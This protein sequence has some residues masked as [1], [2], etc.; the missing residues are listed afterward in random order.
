MTPNGRTV[1]LCM[2]VKDE[3][4]VIARCLASVR[5]I[6]DH[7]IIVDTGS[8]DG[9]QDVVRA[10]MAG[11]PGEL[12]E[13]PWVDFA[14]NRSEALA[15]A[16]P[17]AD[18][19]FI[20]DA[21]DE[22]ALPPGFALPA[23]D[24]DSC[25]I[26]I[27]YSA[28]TYQ[29][30][31]FVRN[32]LEW[33]YRGVIH[34]FLECPAATTSA[35]VPIVMKINHEGRRSTDP[36]TYAKDAAI[37]E[38]ALASESD[39]FLVSRYTFYLAQSWRDCGEREKA[40]A[41]YLRR[42]E[43]GYWAEEVFVSL[44]NAGRLME[45]LGRRED[46]IVGIY[47]RATHVA[48]TRAEALHAASRF[49]RA[50]DRFEDGYWWAKRGIG[51][52]VPGA[53]LFVEPWIFEYGLLDELAVHA[54]WSERFDECRDACDR[55]LSE[56]KM[57]VHM[58]GRVE[59]N[60]Q[61]AIKRLEEVSSSAAPVSLLAPQGAMRIVATMTTIPSRIE[62]IEPV[63]E[64]VLNQ[65]KPVAHLEINIPQFC[66]RTG[67][68][69]RIPDWL[70]SNRKVRIYRTEDYGPI[71]K[72]APTL[73]RYDVDPDTYIWSVDDDCVYPQNQLEILCRSHHKGTHRILT[74][75]GGVLHDDGAVQF[76]YGQ[77]N[78]SMLEGFGGVLYPPSCIKSDFRRFIEQTSCDQD[79]VKNDD[80]VLA[81]YFNHHAIPIYL[82]NVPST[83]VPYMV[84]G[85]LPHWTLDALSQMNHLDNYR[86][87]HAKISK[88][89][90]DGF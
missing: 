56:G 41:A 67:E 12:V 70:A 89:L 31:Q 40:L 29:R 6:L 38:R 65:S 25:T 66:R 44:L 18:Y 11:L 22:L 85:W 33:C 51:L 73:L 10:A 57:P 13:R 5:P 64:A 76:L 9:T 39:P 20:I 63:I 35:H 87:I 58:Q 68:D 30:P 82:Y 45:G 81:M 15:L 17:R 79:C 77:S 8:T 28:T 1:C 84:E 34:E 23:L 50:K 21:D 48:P 2:I 78:V 52:A 36:T 55:L 43:L 37:L 62:R 61:F 3:A 26:D 24:A 7:W 60:R 90:R 54:Y 59:A 4:H 53:G 80:I 46:E 27:N 49:C 72:V 42:A 69:Y 75:Y 19:S 16:Q 32:A 74:R 71:T 14:H 47:A 83:E 86:I 88:M